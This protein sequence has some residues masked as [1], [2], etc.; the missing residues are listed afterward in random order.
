MSNVIAGLVIKQPI[1][2]DWRKIFILFSI[3]YF[4]GGIAYILLG[5]A[6]PEPWATLKASE[7]QQNNDAVAVEEEAVPMQPSEESPDKN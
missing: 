5:S 7:K 6:V 3:I 2:A 1:L 4:I